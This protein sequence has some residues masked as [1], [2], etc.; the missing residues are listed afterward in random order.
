M[1][2]KP[3]VCALEGHADARVFSLGVGHG[4]STALVRGVTDLGAYGCRP[5]EGVAP[6]V[7]APHHAQTQ[8]R[9]PKNSKGKGGSG[10]FAKR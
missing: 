5:I 10:R 9:A 4:V 3:F 1:M 7:R 8:R 6:A 2:A